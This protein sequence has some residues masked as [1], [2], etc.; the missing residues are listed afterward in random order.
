MSVVRVGELANIGH[1]PAH[2]AATV[3]HLVCIIYGCVLLP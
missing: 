3:Y 2:V 1:I